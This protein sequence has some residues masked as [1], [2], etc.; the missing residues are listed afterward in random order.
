VVTF[1][2]AALL[3]KDLPDDS[4]FDRGPVPRCDGIDGSPVNSH[5]H[6][7]IVVFERG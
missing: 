2:I 4:W 7:P 5:G 3:A 6:N 1:C